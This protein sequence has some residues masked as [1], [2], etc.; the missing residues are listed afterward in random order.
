[1]NSE[2]RT[3]A[4]LY[5]M[6]QKLGIPVLQPDQTPRDV[7]DLIADLFHAWKDE[8]DTAEARKIL[9]ALKWISETVPFDEAQQLMFGVADSETREKEEEEGQREKDRERK[10]IQR[11]SDRALNEFLAGFRIIGGDDA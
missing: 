5:E 6:L 2:P 9:N 4:E 1:M 3:A 11:E 8:A 7:Q 10:R